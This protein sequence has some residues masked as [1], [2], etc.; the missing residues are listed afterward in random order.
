MYSSIDN[1]INNLY[2]LI[3]N[4]YSQ[5]TD[6]ELTKTWN[7][8]ESRPLTPKVEEMMDAIMDECSRRDILA[9]DAQGN[10]TARC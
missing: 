3:M 1:T 5:Y 8:L 6:I 4:D 10:I 9:W 2:S 7:C